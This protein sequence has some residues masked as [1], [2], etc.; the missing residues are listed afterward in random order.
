VC[1]YVCGFAV[2]PKRHHFDSFSRLPAVRG[3]HHVPTRLTCGPHHRG[4]GVSSLRPTPPH[5]WPIV[6]LLARLKTVSILTPPPLSLAAHCPVWVQSHASQMTGAS[7]EESSATFGTN[8]SFAPPS[9]VLS[10]GEDSPQPEEVREGNAAS[11]T[12]VKAGFWGAFN[13]VAKGGASTNPAKRITT[14]I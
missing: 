7:W 9:T 1:V 11:A 12:T 4:A 10:R 14:R 3:V 2:V 6:F 8:G 13:G 5:G